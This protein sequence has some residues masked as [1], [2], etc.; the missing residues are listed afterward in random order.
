VGEAPAGGPEFQLHLLFEGPRIRSEKD[1]EGL[2]LQLRMGLGRRLPPAG[3][4]FSPG[5]ARL[6]FT[7]ADP[8]GLFTD[9]LRSLTPDLRALLRHALAVDGSTPAATEIFWKDGS[10]AF[11]KV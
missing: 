4:S 11:R 5:Q 6:F 2:D 3:S 7:T 10:P 1:V 8:G 9:I